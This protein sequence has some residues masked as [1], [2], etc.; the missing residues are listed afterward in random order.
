MADSSAIK[1]SVLKGNSVNLKE[2]VKKSLGEKVSASEILNEGLIKGV[3]IV[4]EKMQ[5]GSM[6]I[7]AVL[8]RVSSNYALKVL[9]QTL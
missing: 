2:L 6:F 9:T 5:E 7:P 1:E 8:S 3:D 4:G